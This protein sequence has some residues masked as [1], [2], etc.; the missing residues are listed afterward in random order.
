MSTRSLEK[1]IKDFLDCVEASDDSAWV[2]LKK[3]LKKSSKMAASK[4]PLRA[5]ET[6]A[7]E[8][9][10]AM[11]IF[12][13]LCQQTD[14][15]SPQNEK[16]KEFLLHYDLPQDPAIFSAFFVAWQSN[17]ANPLKTEPVAPLNKKQR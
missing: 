15:M 16:L 11:L 6:G 2:P 1:A 3:A 17:H 9:E 4:K 13:Y 12:S 7:K 5:Q 10:F 8:I 14:L